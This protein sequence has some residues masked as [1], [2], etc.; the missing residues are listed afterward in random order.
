VVLEVTAVTDKG[1]VIPVAKKEFREIGLDLDGRQKMGSWEIKEIVDLALQPGKTLRERF[2]AELPDDTRSAEVEVKVT[3]WPSPKK[4]LV[5][6][7]VIR[8]VEF[9]RHPQ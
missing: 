8:R 7:R 6:D 1:M 2:V 4:E 5:M 9:E 3:M